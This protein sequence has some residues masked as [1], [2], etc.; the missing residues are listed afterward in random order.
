[1]RALRPALLTLNGVLIV[2]SSPHRKVG[3][4]HDAFRKYFANDSEQRA[5]YI[6]AP[7]RLLNP[8]LSEQEI[9]ALMQADPTSGVSEYLG[10]F[11]T[12]IDAFLDDHLIDQAT[13]PNRRMLP[14]MPG[15]T[16]HAFCD[17]SGGRGDSFTCAV[18]HAREKRRRRARCDSGRSPPFQPEKVVQ[19]MAETLGAYGLRRVT[20]DQYAGEWVS[21]MFKKYGITYQPSEQTKSELYMESL[22]LFSQGRVE[23]LDHPRLSTELRLLERRARA[24]SRG[25]TVD[26]PQGSQGRR[27]KQCLRSV[28]RRVAQAK[29]SAGTTP[30][31]TLCRRHRRARVGMGMNTVN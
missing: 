23:L 26:Q 10:Q 22:P 12:D 7:S 15:V 13:V 4:L 25:D 8:L 9:E 20:G 18:A 11:R 29:P 3:L 30:T 19:E 21:S 5:I 24:G 2:I 6:Q 28:G 16:Y 31:P 17:P 1:M 14:A 27:F